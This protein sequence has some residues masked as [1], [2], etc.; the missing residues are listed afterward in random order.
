ME[1]PIQSFFIFGFPTGIIVLV[2]YCLCYIDDNYDDDHHIRHL[3]QDDISDSDGEI[4]YQSIL[5]EASVD[6]EK[7]KY[8]CFNFIFC[9]F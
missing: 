6:Q 9:F 1:A 4:E 7:S 5:N 3:D 8:S 2:L